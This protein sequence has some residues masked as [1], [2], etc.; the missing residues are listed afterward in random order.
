MS[1]GSSGR[2]SGSRLGERHRLA[3]QTP[4]RG[5]GRRIRSDLQ[6]NTSPAD[7]KGRG[8]QKGAVKVR[9]GEALVLAVSIAFVGPGHTSDSRLRA[10][11]LSA[12]GPVACEADAGRVEAALRPKVDAARDEAAFKVSR[13]HGG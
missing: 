2:S 1:S 10:S 8:R 6:I 4:V 7:L 9:D 11:R 5:P 13:Q 3:G 12:E